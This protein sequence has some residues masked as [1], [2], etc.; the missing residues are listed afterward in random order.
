MHKFK[1]KVQ[2][3]KNNLHQLILPLNAR[4]EFLNKILK[5]LHHKSIIL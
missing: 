2:P 4:R 5:K 3:N 1:E